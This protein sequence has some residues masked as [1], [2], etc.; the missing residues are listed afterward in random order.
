MKVNYQPLFIRRKGVDSSLRLS[1]LML[2]EPE[3]T[4]RTQRK[5][6]KKRTTYAIIDVKNFK[7]KILNLKS[8][9]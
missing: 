7:S 4:Q 9:I 1:Y 5:R 8:K 2:F 6:K 3:R